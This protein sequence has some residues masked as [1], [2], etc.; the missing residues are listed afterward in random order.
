MLFGGIC[1]DGNDIALEPSSVLGTRY[2]LERRE[3]GMINLGGPAVVSVDGTEYR[4]ANRDALY[5]G[6]GAEEVSARAATAKE[7]PKEVPTEAPTEAPKLY[8]ASTTAHSTHPTTHVTFKDANP[9][10]LGSRE[11]SNTRTIYQYVHPKVL[12]S[13][14]LAMGMTVLEPEN[15]W[16]T[17]PC[18]THDRRMEVYLYFD[19]SE[20]DVVFHLMGAPG[21]TRHL[22]VRN[23][24]AVISPNWSIHS[25]VGTSNYTFI[26]AMAGENQ[27]FTDMDA[28]PMAALA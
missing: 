7:A 19:L 23:E 1:P 28:V 8:L 26:W 15:V 2:F 18:H 17:M 10:N 11:Q 5:I 20:D 25:G 4:L 13:C 14:Q 16:N 3:L 9:V 22:V 24:Q 6:M 27:E 12:S 21:E